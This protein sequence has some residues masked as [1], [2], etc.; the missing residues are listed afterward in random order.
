MRRGGIR[1]RSLAAIGAAA[2][3]GS[4]LAASPA[5]ASGGSVGGATQRA[6]F[7]IAGTLCPSDHPGGSTVLVGSTEAEIGLVTGELTVEATASGSGT[8]G[9]WRLAPTTSTGSLQGRISIAGRRATLSGVGSG[10]LTGTRIQAQLQLSIDEGACS[11]GVA[12]DGS[13]R[14]KRRAPAAPVGAVQVAG[15]KPVAQAVAD[16]TTAIEANPNLNLVRTVDHQAAAASRGLALGPTV[17]L[18][19]GNPRLGTPLMRAAQSTGIDLPQKIL[20]WEDLLG[21]TRVA[22]NA[23]AYLQSRHGIVGADAQL[24]VISSALAG[25]AGVAAGADVTPTFDAGQV[26]LGAG[27]V[28]IESSLTPE[29]AFAAIVSALDAAP[30]VN[31]AIEVEH[32]ANAARAGLDLDPTKL[33][34]FG[35][36]SLGTRLMQTRRSVALDLPQKILVSQSGDGPTVITWNDPHWV[37]DRHDL[38]GQ[39]E[40]LDLLA[41]ALA[42]FA[43][44]GQ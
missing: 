23:P 1:R 42:S 7:D 21:S 11:G 10:P 13:G 3:L 41:G 29:A 14:A 5:A 8:R 28:S 18:F 4:A 24:G 17:E 22:Y 6:D 35:N 39:D 2:M 43:S 36:P 26:P 40:V 30:P 15:V 9:T 34:V 44:R 12:I 19:F 33:V 20:I 27:L 25:L 32:D 16:L 38:T 31:V 37:A